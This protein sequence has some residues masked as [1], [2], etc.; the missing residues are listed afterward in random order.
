MKYIGIT[1]SNKK[2]LIDDDKY[3]ILSQWKWCTDPDPINRNGYA[4]M[5]SKPNKSMHRFLMDSP[6]GLIVDHINHDRL[7][8]RLENLRV[9]TV[10]GNQLNL[11][12]KSKK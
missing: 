9:V 7:D 8:N 12:K 3:E 6:E 10:R 2:V 11:E 5:T 4:I 1:N